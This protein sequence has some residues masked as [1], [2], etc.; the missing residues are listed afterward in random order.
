MEI[1]IQGHI[2]HLMFIWLLGVRVGKG[3]HHCPKFLIWGTRD[4]RR[5]GF[6]TYW[7]LKLRIYECLRTC[8]G[9]CLGGHWKCGLDLWRDRSWRR[10]IHRC[11]P[12]QSLKPWEWRTLSRESLSRGGAGKDTG[13]Q[14]GG[15]GAWEG[16]GGMR[17]GQRREHSITAL[18][19]LTKEVETPS[20]SWELL[21]KKHVT[22]LIPCKVFK[23]FLWL[24]SADAF[25]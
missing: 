14:R 22:F 15:W 11:Q 12:G 21:G 24:R 4:L 9:W 7:S 16:P 20:Q 19:W 17:E 6:G 1:L 13:K 5:S 18:T 3:A 23:P 25:K 2:Q 10:H 8:R